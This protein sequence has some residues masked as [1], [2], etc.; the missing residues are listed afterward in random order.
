LAL[1]MLV[2][3]GKNVIAFSARQLNDVVREVG[4][5]KKNL[6]TS[7]GM[8]AHYRVHSTQRL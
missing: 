6:L 2:E 7:F 5:D 1:K 4:L 8:H 3:H